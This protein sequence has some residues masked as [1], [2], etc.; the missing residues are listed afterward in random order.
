[1]TFTGVAPTVPRVRKL[2]IVLA[3]AG[4]L[5]Y[6]PFASGTWGSLMGIP[7]FWM[8]NGLAGS[9]VMAVTLLAVLVLTSCWIAGRA[10]EAF[11]EHDSGKIVI[12]EVV[13][14]M[15]ATLFLPFDLKTIIVAFIVFRALDVIKPYP[16]NY[17]DANFPGGY[18]VVLDDEV[19]GIYS[20]VVTRI[21][22]LFLPF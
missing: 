11:G 3:S 22:L 7:G 10:E 9:P 14:Y 12:D 21:L 20:N 6:M 16:A 1:L 13:G 5:G 18:G 15:A 17:I 8:M 2:I 19:S 4:Y